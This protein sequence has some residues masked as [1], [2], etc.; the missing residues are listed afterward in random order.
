MKKLLIINHELVAK[1]YLLFPTLLFAFAVTVKGNVITFVWPFVFAYTM[2]KVMPFI[3]DGRLNLAAWSGVTKFCS[4]SAL[5]GGTLALIGIIYR[6]EWVTSLGAL[7]VSFGT[8]GLNL[9]GDPNKKLVGSKIKQVNLIA[10]IGVIIGL[11]ILATLM[12]KLSLSWGFVFYDFL[13]FCEVLYAYLVVK[14]E[15]SPLKLTFP[16]NLRTAFPDLAVLIVVLIISFFKKTGRI[17]DFSWALIILAM[18]GLILDVKHILGQPFKMFRI[19]LGA[20]KNYLIIDTLLLA[21]QRN[22]RSWIF[23]VF[24]ELMLGGILAKAVKRRFKQYSPETRYKGM[25]GLL[26]IGLL[27]TY[28]GN[29][30]YLIGTGLTAFCVTILGG[31]AKEQAPDHFNNADKKIAVFG[32]LCNQVILFGTLEIISI[33]KFKTNNALL[34]PYISHHEAL[35]DTSEMLYLRVIMILIF[36][37]TGIFVIIY[38][39][40]NFSTN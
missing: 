40:K 35:Q 2:E 21:F 14:T 25:L 33:L 32:S 20:I 16:F 26:L 27:L 38:D 13:L 31:W 37:I 11:L 29:W 36:V 6:I 8:T 19:W 12:G 5:I 34:I 22:E 28:Y 15:P 39:R 30:T 4:L 23:V 7:G 3:L 18:I 9:L 10:G 1:S 24:I 17:T